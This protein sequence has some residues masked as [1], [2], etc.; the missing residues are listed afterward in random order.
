MPGVQNPHCRPWFSRNACWT[1]L[2]VPSSATRPSAVVTERSLGLDGEHRAGLDRLAVEQH[3]A[4]AAGGGVAADVGGAQAEGLPQVV[5]EQQPRLDLVAAADPVDR[6][7]DLHHGIRPPSSR[8]LLDGPPDPLGRGGHVDVGDAE[9]GHRVDDRV[10]HR[11]RGADR[12]GLA[13]A[14]GAERVVAR[15]RLHLDQLEARHLGRRQERVVGERRGQRVA[16]LVVDDLL[17]ERLGGALR[18]AAV[19]LALGQQRVHDRAGV[20]DGH[21]P[22]EEHLAGLGIDLDDRHVGAER[23]RRPRRGEHAAHEQPL[24]LGQAATAAP[25]CPGPP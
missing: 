25:R 6:E 3:R 17:E 5:D 10:L 11:G 24:R 7:L 23:E 18:D 16:V 13:D 14:L 21:D 4:G 22:A 15:G 9:V 20:V 8:W 1:R 19:P 12:A 2:I